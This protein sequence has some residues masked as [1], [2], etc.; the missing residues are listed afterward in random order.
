MT[1][2]VAV[3]V[4]VGVNVFVGAKPGLNFHR[5]PDV[6]FIIYKLSFT[7][8]D[9]PLALVMVHVVTGVGLK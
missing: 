7:S 2:G 1:V 3:N 6:W 9:I 8:T 5:Y 4:A